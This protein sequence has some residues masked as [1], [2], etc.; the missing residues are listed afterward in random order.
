MVVVMVDE[1]VVRIRRYEVIEFR[2]D[3]GNETDA[4]WLAEQKA[5][6]GDMPNDIVEMGIEWL[7]VVS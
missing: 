5:T 7:E 4:A 6:N 3:A 1:Y 2:V